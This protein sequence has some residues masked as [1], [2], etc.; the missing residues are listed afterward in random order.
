[1]NIKI[2]KIILDKHMLKHMG[3]NN[4]KYLAMT[5]DMETIN[6]LNEKYNFFLNKKMDLILSKCFINSQKK[7]FILL[8]LIN[9]ILFKKSINYNNEDL[10]GNA[11]N[12]N[13]KK[14]FKIR[15]NRL[16]FNFTY[17][18]F[19]KIVNHSLFNYQEPISEGDDSIFLEYILIKPLEIKNP[20]TNTE[21]SYNILINFYHFCLNN[22]INIPITYKLFYCCNFHI[23]KFFLQNEFLI[24]KMT[25]N[26]FIKNL[27]MEKKKKILMESVDVLCKFLLKYF[28]NY[29]L[30]SIVI[31]Y[32]ENII[33][34]NN[35][36]IENFNK[37]L[38]DYYL[39]NY[40][41]HNKQNK[42]F[43]QYKLK[44]IMELLNNECIKFIPE[45]IE[46][47][48]FSTNTILNKI[49]HNME[50]IVNEE[51]NSLFLSSNI[52]MLINYRRGENTNTDNNINDSS[53]NL[54]NENDIS[55]SN[56]DISNGMN[57]NNNNSLELLNII[58]LPD[59]VIDFS[60]INLYL[61][62]ETNNNEELNEDNNDQD[63]N[64]ENNNQ[65][66]D[67]ENNIDEENIYD[68]D[69]DYDQVNSEENNY[70]K[71]DNN[72][73]SS[74]NEVKNIEYCNINLLNKKINNNVDN[75]SSNIFFYDLMR[76]SISKY[77]TS[78]LFKVTFINLHLLINTYILC[79]IYNKILHEIKLTAK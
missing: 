3:K 32:Q 30:K 43:L 17:C 31:K 34:M 4:P 18:D 69:S 64:D 78:K 11:I 19:I 6:N 9:K 71:N 10:I 50:Y 1:M 61:N 49:T 5:N 68:E 51:L 24:Y 42:I 26:S 29:I 36:L 48:I 37:I 39:M 52:S 28:K 15:I 7:Y 79:F 59:D 2:F 25:V 40:F 12:S 16:I 58:R 72:E 55:N 38:I 73:I 56:I 77:I 22:Y 67:D 46:T 63:N 27:T 23:K 44:I 65:D 45:N 13:S 47:D 54:N 14:I 8:S 66:N 60:N 21:L 53:Y 70:M 41:L 62:R 57:I 33:T 74:K 75:K 76:K 35:S 20:Y